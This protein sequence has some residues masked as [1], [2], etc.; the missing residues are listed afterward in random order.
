MVATAIQPTFHVKALQ[1][2]WTGVEEKGSGTAGAE[3][4]VN[5]S[6]SSCLT[7]SSMSCVDVTL[8]TVTGFG[9]LVV[10]LSVWQTETGIRRNNT[11]AT[12]DTR[13][14]LFG[15]VVFATISTLVMIAVVETENLC[16]P[17]HTMCRLV[18]C[19]KTS[20]FARLLGTLC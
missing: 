8:E 11:D 12:R 1:Y 19:N 7:G 3:K 13:W 18:K 5:L 6:R 9:A 10:M 16:F 14:A 2:I 20:E 17:F 15:N 4:H